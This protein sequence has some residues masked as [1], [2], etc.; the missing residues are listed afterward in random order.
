M[1]NDFLT[2]TPPANHADGLVSSETGYAARAARKLF[3]NGPRRTL[4]I[5]CRGI[6]LTMVLG[7]SIDHPTARLCVAFA[8]HPNFFYRRR[9]NRPPCA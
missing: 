6:R 9:P 5:D 2:N 7:Q 4:V 8:R 3:G 1:N